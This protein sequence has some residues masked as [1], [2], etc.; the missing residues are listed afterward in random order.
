MLDNSSEAV[1]IDVSVDR[2]WV[3]AWHCM[4]EDL[5]G[6]GKRERMHDCLSR[7]APTLPLPSAQGVVLLTRRT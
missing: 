4:T 3:E 2:P 7:I 5:Q 6:G 1:K